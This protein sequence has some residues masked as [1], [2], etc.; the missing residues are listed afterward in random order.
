MIHGEQMLLGAASPSFARAVKL[1]PGRV[2][3]AP[4]GSTISKLGTITIDEEPFH[5]GEE[6]GRRIGDELGI[7]PERVR[8]IGNDGLRQAQ[9]TILS[10]WLNAAMPSAST[11]AL[12]DLVVFAVTS[13]W[14]ARLAMG[15]IDIDDLIAAH[16]R[17][18][19]CAA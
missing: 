11:D 1:R 18:K 9:V 8:Q 5:R 4:Q 16:E 17:H 12:S 6:I 10:T 7:S 3:R 14:G 15:D 19:V 13:R 2:M